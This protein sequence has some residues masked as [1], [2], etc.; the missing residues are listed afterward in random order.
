VSADVRYGL[1]SRVTVQGGWDVFAKEA[2][3]T[4]WQPYA[5]A[6]AAVLRSLLLTG[7][8][9][10]NGH[11]RGAWSTSRAPICASRPAHELRGS[12]PAVRAEPPGERRTEAAV[13]WRP[14][15]SS[16]RPTC[17]G[18]RCDRPGRVHAHDRAASGTAQLGRLRYTFG[19]RHDGFT[20]DSVTTN[21]FAVDAGADGVLQSRRPWLSGTSIRAEASVEP[22]NGLSALAASVGRKVGRLLRADVGVGWFA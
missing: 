14:G 3:G 4:L 20:R 13:L 7:E 9:V 16:G 15:R 18:S 19:L 10:V 17:R 1:S 8:A 21:R 6:S 12:G 11:L 22:A 5:V 2:G